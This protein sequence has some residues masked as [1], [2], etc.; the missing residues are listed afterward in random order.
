MCS[1]FGSSRSPVSPTIQGLPLDHLALVANRTYICRSHRNV[2]NRE[3][4]NLPSIYDTA[5]RH[6]RNAQ[7]FHER[8]LF[9][10]LKSHHL[11]DRLLTQ[12]TSRGRLQSSVETRKSNECNLHTLPRPWPRSPV[13]LT[14]RL[15]YTSGD[16][17]FVAAT[18]RTHSLIAWLW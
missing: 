6:H 15:V 11:R 7:S 12:H 4:L 2:T 9:A 17:A 5:Q 10:S 14:K 8:D 3:V 18:Q 13:S 1:P 16:L